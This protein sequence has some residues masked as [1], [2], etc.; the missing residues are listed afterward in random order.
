MT[1]EGVALE[2]LAAGPACG[3]RLAACGPRNGRARTR[4]EENGWGKAWVRRRMAIGA[5][6]LQ[7]HYRALAAADP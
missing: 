5:S 1:P 7:L 6:R 3:L 4:D 2:V